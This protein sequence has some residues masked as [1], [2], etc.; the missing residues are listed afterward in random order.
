M[1]RF[2]GE[3]CA[4]DLITSEDGAPNPRQTSDAGRFDVLLHDAVLNPVQAQK[5]DGDLLHKTL[6]NLVLGEH[7]DDHQE[8]PAASRLPTSEATAM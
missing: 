4:T 5:V 7:H 1:S 8:T 6:Q 3:N 2:P